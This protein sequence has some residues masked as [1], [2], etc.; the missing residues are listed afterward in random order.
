MF[1]FDQWTNYGREAF[2]KPE[3]VQQNTYVTAKSS[4]KKF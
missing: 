4:K 1:K 3:T 2:Q